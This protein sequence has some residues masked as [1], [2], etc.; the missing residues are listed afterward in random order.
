MQ[1]PIV[2]PS[3]QPHLFQ[4]RVYYAETDAGGVVY[5]ASYLNF[6]ERARIEFL[7]EIGHNVADI[8]DKEG[9]I[10][11]VRQ[12][13]IDYMAPARLDDWLIIQSEITR[14]G[15]ASLEFRQVINKQA[16][17]DI[18]PLTAL[19]VTLVAVNK[20]GKASRIPAFLR[21]DLEKFCPPQNGTKSGD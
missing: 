12:C 6:A 18:L 8:A 10:F 20:D 9:L 21:D 3:M 14:I 11:A 2:K 15:G 16:G 13:H 1:V 7:R 19:N 17:A 4:T 5:H